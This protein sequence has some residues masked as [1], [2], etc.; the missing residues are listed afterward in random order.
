MNRGLSCAEPVSWKSTLQSTFDS[1]TSETHSFKVG[2]LI[3]GNN[4]GERDP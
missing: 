2:L 4:G 1:A 3:E